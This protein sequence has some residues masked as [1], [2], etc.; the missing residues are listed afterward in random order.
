MLRYNRCLSSFSSLLFSLCFFGVSPSW[1]HEVPQEPPT[2]T[3]TEKGSI[4]LAPDKA[5]VNLSVETAGVALEDVQEENRKRMSRVMGSLKKLGVKKEQ[6]Q[7]S[8]LTVTPQY[9][10]RPRVQSNQSSGPY[11]PKIIGYTVSNALAVEVLN[12]DIVGRVVDSALESGANRFS[13][14]T[15]A[16]RDERPARL[17][18]LK[19]A[20]QQARD[21]AKILAN[22][23]GVKLVKLLEVTEGGSPV[24]QRRTRGRAMMSMAMED[25]GSVPVSPGELTVRATVTLV[26]EIHQE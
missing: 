13:H 23:L 21:K 1:G 2:L 9:P 11:I 3:V 25:A 12:L 4:R 7:T 8:S 20:A 17:K 6:I 22:S 18:A 16:L 24:P 26:Y 10:P 5:L 15:W 14:I 19:S